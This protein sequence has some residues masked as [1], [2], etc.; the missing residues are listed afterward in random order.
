M[1]DG[2]GQVVGGNAT[3]KAL[4]HFLNKDEVKNMMM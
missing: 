3:D 1:F 4:L 2:D